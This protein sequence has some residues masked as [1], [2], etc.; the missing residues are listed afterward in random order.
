MVETR[1]D[2]VLSDESWV[3]VG[4]PFPNVSILPSSGGPSF[5]LLQKSKRK[6]RPGICEEGGVAHFR[7]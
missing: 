5:V 2:I 4:C 1:I 7:W 6:Y 3:G